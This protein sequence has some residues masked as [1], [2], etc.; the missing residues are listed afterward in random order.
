MGIS[1]MDNMGSAAM[2]TAG[3]FN[4]RFPAD[5][6]PNDW[7]NRRSR[8][9][10]TV[11]A[12]DYDIFGTQETVPEYVTYITENLPYASIGHGREPD[13]S[14]EST[15]IFYH[16]ERVRLISGETFWLSETPDEY[17]K[18]WGTVC[19]R[20]GT[21]G[22]FEDR[23]SGKRFIFA[24]LHLQHMEMYECQKNQLAVMFERLKKYPA[25]LPVI[26]TGDFNCN[27]EHPAALL[28]S[29]FLCDT[30]RVSETPAAGMQYASYHAF[31]LKN[32]FDPAGKPIDYIFISGG[33][34]VK[35][36][37][38]VNNFDSNGLASSDHFPLKAEIVL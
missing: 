3:S 36:F 20:I 2:I 5:P 24:N 31:D 1:N 4:L 8:V 12:L 11:T 14:G 23:K 30:R 10:D 33:V 6:A 26:L 19:P 29:E 7:A 34:R 13:K 9:A 21:I 17:S 28:A 37:E 25:E 16:P 18:S 15:A 38:T 27:P 22:V 32:G 35:S